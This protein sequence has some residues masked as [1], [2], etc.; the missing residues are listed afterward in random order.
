ML[1][2]PIIS[3][4]HTGFFR[5]TAKD[6]RIAETPLGTNRLRKTSAKW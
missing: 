3:A 2:E 5:R 4:G 6:P 1:N